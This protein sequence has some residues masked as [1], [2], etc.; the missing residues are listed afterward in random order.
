MIK[1]KYL[2]YIN[3]FLTLVAI[4]MAYRIWFAPK[5]DAWNY[6]PDNAFLVVESSQIQRSLFN[7]QGFDSTQL[8]DIPFFYDALQPLKKIVQSVDENE[9]AEKFLRRKR[10]TYSLHRE[11]K[12]NLEYIIYIPMGTFGAAEFLNQLT[13]PD[14]SKRKVY[15]RTYKGTRID[16]LYTANNLL[17][18]NFLIHDDFLIC[19]GSKVL[20]EEV[21]NRIKSGGATEGFPFKES[22]RGIAHIYFKSR[23]LQDVADILPSQL[24]PNL[25]E[26][27][28]NIAPRNPD[29]VFEKPK[30]PNTVSAYIYSKGTNTIPFLG[31]FSQQ[32]PQPFTC[33]DLIPEN[34][35]ITFRISFKNKNKLAQDFNNYFRGNEQALLAE[36]DSLNRFL[37]INIP[38][39]YSILKNEVVLCE[40]ETS[41]DEPSKKI[42]LIKT[43][44][45]ADA[46]NMFDDLADNAEKLS[47]YFKPQP[48][49]YLNN[50][51]RKIQISQL[52]ALLFGSIFR[53]FADCYYTQIGDYMILASDDDAMREYLNNLNFGQ[54]WAKSNIY[55]DF[56]KKLRPQAQVTAI[57]S[58]QRIWNNLYYSLPQKWR[59]S[60]IK[61]EQRAKAIR[62]VAV[63][64]FVINNT[65]GTKLLIE[66][67]PQ[68]QKEVLV[69]RF[70]LQDSL[71]ANAAFVGKPFIIKN[72][73][74]TS[75][76]ILLQRADHQAVLLSNAAK[77][78]NTI[79]LSQPLTSAYLLPTDYFQNGTL[80][81]LATTAD[82]LL[83]FTRENQTGLVANYADIDFS[84][85]IRAVA[86]SE[87]KIYVA[88]DG[89]N[90]YVINE[91]TQNISKVK[92]P[93]LLTDIMRIQPVKY[94]NN[95]YLAI[96]QKDGT[97]NVI[98][99]QGP[100]LKGFPK[101]PL[102]ARP[103]EMVIEEG[104]GKNSIITLISET[105]EI[106][107]V[108]MN[109]NS[110]DRA[111]IQLERPD[112][113]TV[114]EVIFDQNHKDWL[115]ARRTPTSLIILNKQGNAVLEI[116]STN[117]M[118]SQLR[119]FDL[120]NDLR[121]VG[122]FD[123]KNNTLFDLKG[124]MLGDKPLA[125]TALP[126]VSYSEA[127]NKLFIYN[128]NKTRFEV[129]TV[130]L[131]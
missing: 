71:S 67:I 128:T 4:Y 39:L 98:Y 44:D 76:E 33:T 30:I 94:K 35:A 68:T 105:G 109:G 97:L 123:G 74:N 79:P 129:W 56:V 103:V 112:K 9:V 92:I 106:K 45:P 108:D 72:A 118:K 104:Q 7:K 117:F 22:R 127:Y 38:S 16:E 52:P 41:S 10:I 59:S 13:K 80:H 37:N 51:V 49:S 15:G 64:N 86:A 8:A 84:G 125:A 130:K 32:M 60:T 122:I 21:V 81:Y 99:E 73:Y 88:D 116:G 121:F 17:M 75:E 42:L 69:N 114:F 34:T 27:F 31:I 58:P 66:K 1:T 6:I 115:I 91:E 124:R 63:E 110:L 107:K 2:W 61:H 50:Y 113:A 89:G 78:V 19:S 119:Y 96:L 83:F 11:T 57:I 62:F 70:F 100:F 131:K 101:V 65:F 18:F 25:I 40:M 23:N 43:E 102:T 77:E 46:L 93:M 87:T 24:S 54:T 82:K 14:P 90:V 12:K 53:G 111:N 3:A 120:G 26:F 47:S 29:I 20:L 5:R 85:S 28:G 36:R 95:T 48:F 55:T 126:A